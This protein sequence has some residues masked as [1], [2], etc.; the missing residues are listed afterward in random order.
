MSISPLMSWKIGEISPRSG[1]KMCMFYTHLYLFRRF[2]NLWIR[3]NNNSWVTF[4]M[5]KIQDR[6]RR[7]D[8]LRIGFAVK[9]IG[10]AN[11]CFIWFFAVFWTCE[12]GE[13]TN[14]GQISPKKNR[15]VELLFYLIFAVLELVRMAKWQI[16]RRFRRKKYMFGEWLLIYLNIAGRWPKTHVLCWNRL[17]VNLQPA[18]TVEQVMMWS[19]FQLF[20]CW[21]T[22][23]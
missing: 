7:N 16:Q 4:T 9:N 11:Y 22:Q 20:R 17:R 14:S 15:I 3:R 2:L 19:I 5:K 8:K 21:K 23:V 6:R 10:S 18:T 1:E 13:M 12:F